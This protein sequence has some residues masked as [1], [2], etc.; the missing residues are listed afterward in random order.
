MAS[1]AADIVTVD[2]PSGAGK[3]TISHLLAE[4]LGYSYLDTG[5]MYRAVGLLIT[6]AGI[7][8]KDE[9]ALAALLDTVVLDLRPTGGEMRVL[10]NGADVSAAIRTAEMGLIASRV[11]AIPAVRRKLTDLQRTIAS[12]GH[13]VAEGRDMGTVV[14]PDARHKFFLDASAEE[15]ARRRTEQLAEKGQFVPYATILEQINR[16]DRD[17]AG[18]ALAPLKPAPDAIV[19]DSSRLSIEAVVETMLAHIRTGI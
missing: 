11:S 16:R 9:T 5:A 6:S 12:R 2:G 8:E 19:I 3:S 17:D 13:Y 7:D 18:R 15:R 10:L 1:K 14:F 4:K